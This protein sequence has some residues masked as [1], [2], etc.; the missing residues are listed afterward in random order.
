MLPNSLASLNTFS[1]GKIIHKYSEFMTW[2]IS[3]DGEYG[4]VLCGDGPKWQHAAAGEATCARNREAGTW[5]YLVI[6]NVHV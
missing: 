6:Q 1:K 3:R 2:R 4:C 5:N